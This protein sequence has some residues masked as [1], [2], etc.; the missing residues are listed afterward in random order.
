MTDS[1]RVLIVDDDAM[2]ASGVTTILETTDDIEVVC[3]CDD[4]DRVAAALPASRPDIVLSD[5]RMPRMDGVTLVQSLRDKQDRPRFIMMTAFDDDGRVLDAIAA[6]ADGFLLKDDDPL[7]IIAAV[8]SVAAGGSAYSPRAARQL[9]EWVRRAPAS[10]AR[11]DAR[12]K[13]DLLTD[14]E[15]EFAI[16]VMNG[17]TDAELA[18]RFFVAPTTVK[19]TLASIRAKWGVRGRVDIAVVAARADA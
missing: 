5:V 15:R 7:R 6:G 13:L 1:I 11:R 14:R 8:R 3:R 4:G 12:A 16:E 10:E 9:T 19:S 2:A 17:L 18:T